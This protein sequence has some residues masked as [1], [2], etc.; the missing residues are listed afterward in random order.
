MKYLK[1]LGLAAVSAM[2]FMAFAST[3]SA[4]TLEETGVTQHD[5]V[6]IT[7][8]LTPETTA[9]LKNTSG[10][11]QNTCTASHVHGVT[12]TF[13][14]THIQG[15]GTEHGGPNPEAGLSFSGCTRLVTVHDPGTLTVEWTSGTNGTVWSKDA[16]VTVRV[17]LI[18]YVH[19]TTVEKT[20]LGELTGVASGHATLHVDAVIDCGA[21]PSAKWEATYT[22]TS[23]HGLGVSS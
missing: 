11:V 9:V 8:S 6:T 10:S 12:T 14:G 2:A 5:S 21:I 19:C 23:P 16:T 18:G 3:A 22:V 13:T 7:A 17:P 1:M 20:H 4:T 15:E